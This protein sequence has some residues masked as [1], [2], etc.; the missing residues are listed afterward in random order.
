M[1]GRRH[2]KNEGEKG[3]KIR[4]FLF[5]QIFLRTFFVQPFFKFLFHGQRRALQL[6]EDNPLSR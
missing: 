5:Q 6:V 2:E 1:R 3:E 4:K